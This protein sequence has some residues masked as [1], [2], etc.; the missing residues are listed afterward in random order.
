MWKQTCWHENISGGKST[1]VNLHLCQQ[2]VKKKLYALQMDEF[3]LTWRDA[4]TGV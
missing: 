4:N 3:C 2:N 1:D